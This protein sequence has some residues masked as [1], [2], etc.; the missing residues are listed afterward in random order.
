MI[1]NS[2]KIIL[3]KESIK[4]VFEIGIH[5]SQGVLYYMYFTCD[6]EVSRVSQSKQLLPQ[7]ISHMQNWDISGMN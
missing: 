2:F 1:G 6:A 4:I 7:F 5:T 3:V